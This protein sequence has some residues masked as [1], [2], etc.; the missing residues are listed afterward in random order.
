MINKY[1]KKKKNINNLLLNSLF[2]SKNFYGESL[3]T[4][5]KKL[6]PFIY[7]SR[8]KYSIINLKY[9]SI[10][11]KRI[12]KLIQII[13]QQ[14]QKILIVGNSENVAPLLNDSLR[15]KKSNKNNPNII[16]FKN[17]WVNGLVTNNQIK[18]PFNKKQIKLIL[19]IKNDV[20]DSYLNTEL[21]SLKVPIISFLN[22]NQNPEKIDYPILMNSLNIKSLYTLLYLIRKNF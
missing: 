6:L 8:H 12:F 16:I 21:S 18:C 3:K 20:E 15:N 1:I 9:T 7:G 10:F 13:I 17:E 2:K 22:T 4:T 5:N 11:L 14:N 19:I